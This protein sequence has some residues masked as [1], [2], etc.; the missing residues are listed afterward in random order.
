VGKL[1]PTVSTIQTALRVELRD[2][3]SHMES[4]G[5]ASHTMVMFK[6]RGSFSTG[7]CRGLIRS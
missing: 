5:L 2:A 7:Y 1:A 3:M 6:L 4:D